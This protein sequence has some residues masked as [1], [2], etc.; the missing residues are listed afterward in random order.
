MRHGRRFRS[1]RRLRRL[2]AFSL[3]AKVKD[4]AKGNQGKTR[5][6]LG[7]SSC[8]SKAAADGDD[9][10]DG[11]DEESQGLPERLR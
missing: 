4:R 6:R 1:A 11:E 10:P 9:R 3:S 8:R 5:E 2:L 7:L